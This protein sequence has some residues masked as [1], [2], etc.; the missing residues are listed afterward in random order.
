VVQYIAE[1]DLTGATFKLDS[2]SRLVSSVALPAEAA[3]LITRLLQDFPYALAIY[4]VEGEIA[5]GIGF[6]DNGRYSDQV[7]EYYFS[8]VPVADGDYP[9]RRVFPAPQW[10]VNRFDYAAA[11]PG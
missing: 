2:A 8:W 7:V 1:H 11:V 5:F 10:V 9:D 3:A 6:E 4:V